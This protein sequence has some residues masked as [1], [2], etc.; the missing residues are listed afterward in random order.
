MLASYFFSIALKSAPARNTK[1]I[2]KYKIQ[3]DLITVQLDIDFDTPE[4]KPLT[5]YEVTLSPRE[6]SHIDLVVA[7]NNHQN[8]RSLLNSFPIHFTTT[9]FLIDLPSAMSNGGHLIVVY[10]LHEYHLFPTTIVRMNQRPL[11]FFN[12]TMNFLSPYPTTSNSIE[13]NGISNTYIQK[14]TQSKSIHRSGSTIK[15]NEPNEEGD[16]EVEYQTS[17][18]FDRINLMQEKT[19]I[20]QW[21]KS[22][23]QA[24]YD[25]KN[26]GPKF[27][28]PF[29]RLDFS[30]STPCKIERVEIRSPFPFSKPWAS[31]ESGLLSKDIMF[32]Q[33]N[34]LIPMRCPMLSSWGATFTAGWYLSTSS[35]VSENDNKFTYK[36]PLLMEV[37]AVSVLKA[38]SEIVL[39]EGAK[40]TNIV[41]PEMIKSKS[42]VTTFT[43]VENLDFKGRTVV[44]VE[45]DYVNS[46]FEIPITIDYTLSPINNWGKIIYLVRMFA[47]FFLSIIIVRR[48]DCG[49]NVKNDKKKD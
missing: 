25:I 20:S 1:V 28:G 39:P 27:T 11:V 7:T 32:S 45:T 5:Q 42:N 13:I 31:D 30:S 17:H 22:H 26:S 10:A 47:V 29:S 40:V 23:Q 36:A 44:R 46:Y 24:F 37:S 9:G 16:F 4:E 15:I 21:G 48:I 38:S 41:L 34:A 19:I 12:C 33:K 6:R 8:I 35:L 3:N 18:S 43:R 2:R 49:I 14:I